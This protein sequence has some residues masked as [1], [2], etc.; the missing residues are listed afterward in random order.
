LTSTMNSL[1]HFFV[2]R[3]THESRHG[4]RHTT[5]SKSASVHTSPSRLLRWKGLG[6]LILSDRRLRSPTETGSV[7]GWR[8]SSVICLVC[9]LSV[10]HTH[11]HICICT[12]K[13]GGIHTNCPAFPRVIP[14]MLR[15]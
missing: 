7:S 3:T 1:I 15:G 10:R 4:W 5:M 13:E 14:Q 2:S 11:G 9:S 8:N 12:Q 6:C